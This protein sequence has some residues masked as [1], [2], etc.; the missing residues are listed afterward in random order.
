MSLWSIVIVFHYVTIITSNNPSLLQKLGGIS[1]PCKHSTHSLRNLSESH[2]VLMSII[3]PSG[4]SSAPHNILQTSNL[5]QSLILLLLASVRLLHF[6]Q[7]CICMVEF[8]TTSALLPHANDEAGVCRRHAQGVSHVLMKIVRCAQLL[9]YTIANLSSRKHHVA[10][11][12]A[13]DCLR[14]LL[15]G[16]VY[17]FCDRASGECLPFLSPLINLS[18]CSGSSLERRSLTTDFPSSERTAVLVTG[19]PGDDREAIRSFAVLYD[20]RR[21]DIV[22][23]PIIVDV[24]IQQRQNSTTRRATSNVHLYTHYSNGCFEYTHA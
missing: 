14:Y 24:G 5:S 15:V 23:I 8:T 12:A 7:R 4:M 20:V 3:L 9:S 22:Y 13:T 16:T 1:W 6:L 17:P 2:S 10:V 19:H 21:F 11:C 18:P